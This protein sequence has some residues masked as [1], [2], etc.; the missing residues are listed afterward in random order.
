M[1]KTKTSVHTRLKCCR[2]ST[3]YKMDSM[4]DLEECCNGGGRVVRDCS[5]CS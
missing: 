5:K 4:Q 3:C 2:H 1:K